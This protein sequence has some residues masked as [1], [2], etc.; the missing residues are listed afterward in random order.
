MKPSEYGGADLKPADKGV[1]PASTGH[2]P[3]A[4]EQLRLDYADAKETE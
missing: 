1:F 2:V 3:T 4:Y